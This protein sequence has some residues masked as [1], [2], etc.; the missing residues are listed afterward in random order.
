M[1]L[2]DAYSGLA[3]PC[4]KRSRSVHLGVVVGIVLVHIKDTRGGRASTKFR[5]RVILVFLILPCVEVWGL[6]FGVEG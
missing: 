3:G 1:Y 6:G 5:V 4:R 2:L